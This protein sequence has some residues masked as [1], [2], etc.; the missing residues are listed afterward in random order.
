MAERNLIVGKT[1]LKTLYPQIAAQWDYDLNE[2]KPEDYSPFSMVR[3]WW[4]CEKEPHKYFIDAKNS[5]KPKFLNGMEIDIYIP[6][7]KQGIE[8]DGNSL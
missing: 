1:D 6:S 4:K 7:L 2:D 3:K 5:Y 8:Y